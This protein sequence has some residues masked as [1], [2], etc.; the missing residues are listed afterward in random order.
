[1]S[2]NIIHIENLYKGFGEKDYR[3]EV[4]KGISLD[5]FEGDFISIMGS[6]G[7]GKSTLLYLI[8]RLDKP[9]SGK[10]EIEGKDI[11]SLKDKEMSKIR[12]ETL[13]FIFQ[14]YNLVPNLTVKENILLPLIMNKLN[15]KD[16]V[17][18]LDTILSYINISNKLN[19]Y[20]KEL[21]GGLQQKTAIARSFTDICQPLF[22]R[23]MSRLEMT[24]RLFCSLHQTR[25][26]STR[27]SVILITKPKLRNP[28][29]TSQATNSLTA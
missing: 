21:S 13:G 10:I 9:D 24:A 8:N 14:F 29:P 27:C 23:H 20:P 1:M 26:S 3:N 6:S 15:P 5:I 11:F 16:Y 25:N 18:R 28:C 19:N 7:C 22:L 12:K 4:I 2:N 17:D